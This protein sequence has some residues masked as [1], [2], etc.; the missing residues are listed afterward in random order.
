MTTTENVVP[1]L[2]HSNLTEGEKAFV[3]TMEE[4]ELQPGCVCPNDMI[5]EMVA[6]SRKFR[7]E[8]FNEHGHHPGDCHPDCKAYVYVSPE[9]S[10]RQCVELLERATDTHEEAVE[11]L[12]DVKRRI[13]KELSRKP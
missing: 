7:A 2:K 8:Y 9:E 12:A 11:L 10:D 6:K 3:Q 13:R 5:L 1:M 4:L